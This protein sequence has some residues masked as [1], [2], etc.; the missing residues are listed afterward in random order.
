MNIGDGVAIAG[1]CVSGA[2]F[3]IKCISFKMQ[4]SNGNGGVNESLCKARMDP[5]KEDLVVIKGS[6]AELLRRVPER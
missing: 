2:A 4:R 6:V 5:I 1:I 3:G